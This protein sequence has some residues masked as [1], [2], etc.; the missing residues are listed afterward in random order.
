MLIFGGVGNSFF[1]GMIFGIGGLVKNGVGIFM[2]GGINLFSGG[3]VLNGGG[4][5]VGNSVVFGSGVLMVGSNVMLDVMIGVSFVNNIG[6]VVGVN[7]DL[8]GS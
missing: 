1:D 2:L 5:V 7:F 8:F 3:V 6:L 4:L